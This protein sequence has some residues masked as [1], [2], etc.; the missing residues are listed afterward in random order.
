[1]KK[2]I[3]TI[4][5]IATIH[6]FGIA[7]NGIT[8]TSINLHATFHHVGIQ[9]NFTGDVNNN[10]IATLEVNIDNA[11][12]QDAHALSR[13]GN[14]RF[15]GT[16]FSLNSET[17]V[18]VRI[19][20]SDP[21]G[22]NNNVHTA[23]IT[24]RSEQVPVSTGNHIHVATSGNDNTGDGSDSNP[25]NTIQKAVDLAIPGNKIVI[26]AGTY[27]ETVEIAYKN[28][29]SIN[30]PITI[31]NAGDGPVI[32]DGTDE[33]YND[34]SIWTN[35]GNN[36]YSS[37]LNDTYYIGI[38][39]NRLWRYN[40]LME[41]QNLIYNTD[42]GFFPDIAA[43]KVYLKL[44]GN[45]NPE[46]FEIS[47]STLGRAFDIFESTHIIIDGLTFRNYNVGEHSSAIQIA[48]NSI[49]L[50]IVNNIF[51]NMETPIRLEEYVEDLVVM[52]NDFSDQ[53]VNILDWD[54]V[55]EFQWWL[56]RGALYITNDG[57]T[58]KGTIFYKNNVYD[59]FDGV[60]IVGSE[61]DF[62]TYAT[63]SDV[64]ENTFYHL[65][66]DGVEVDGFSCNIRIVNNRFENLL[67]GV[68]VAP[69]LA[70][71]VYIVRNL[72]ADLN[73]V[74]S[75]D[76]ETTA[77]KFNYDGEKSGEIF[78]YHNIGS[79][80]EEEQAAI[81][82][83][84]DSNWDNLVI[85]NNI[86]SGTLFAF[87]H[88]L[89]NTSNLTMTHDSDLLYSTS[90]ILVLFDETEYLTVENY[91][92]GTNLCQN[93]L[94]ND[95][96]FVDDASGDYHLNTNSP[97]I[98]QAEIIMGINENY[99]GSAPDM[100][101]YEQAGS[102]LALE[103]FDDLKANAKG[104][105]VYLSWA[106]SFEKEND[107]FELER[108]GNNDIWRKIQHVN[109][110][111]NSNTVTQYNTI[112]RTPLDGVSYY[113]LKQFDIHGN[114][115]FSNVASVNFEN[116]DFS[117]F[118]NPSNGEIEL[119]FG[120]NMDATIRVLDAKGST[121]ILKNQTQEQEK[122]DLRHLPNGIYWITIQSNKNSI[123]KKLILSK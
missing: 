122:L 62:T 21:E 120:Q 113:R 83:T 56:E 38:N 32:L 91:F 74:A 39:G 17:N 93:C 78:V 13:V 68:S 49:G 54:Y 42:G 6:F 20:L 11:G 109:S 30:A 85:K 70:G 106:T 59:M 34:S 100:G 27:H 43:N 116:L 104:S 80:F 117:Y 37:P 75:P 2:S 90:E 26:H 29:S 41:L 8:G 99:L 115:S 60:K 1:M 103:F 81:S 63:N 61:D 50:W 92:T 58:G 57:F 108:K 114:Y 44:P 86:W 3:I 40:T 28:E 36:I 98:D 105:E 12:F 73:N 52:S 107:F 15:V 84:N 7:Q 121:L 23:S 112:D 48:D 72:M 16:V 64:E 101:I 18:D 79:T 5:L 24:T 89:D 19:T 118:P 110:K 14:N 76:W 46:G 94:N 66:D 33:S 65:S 82:I 47:V 87:Y 71:P 67:A 102:S 4:L 55:K 111:H 51:E 22:V 35:E 77:I 95:P 96:L 25:Y 45:A 123:S 53:G 97:A 69:A 10:A 88:W 31:S 9:V 119:F